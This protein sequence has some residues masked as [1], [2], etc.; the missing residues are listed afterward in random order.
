MTFEDVKH[1]FCVQDGLLNVR[2]E[3]CESW[4]EVRKG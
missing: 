4:N 2:L 3:G 1:R